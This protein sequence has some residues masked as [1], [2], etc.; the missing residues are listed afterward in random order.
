M[1]CEKK[2]YFAIGAIFKNEAHIMK[3]WLNHYFYHGVDHIYLINDNSNDNFMDILTP[4]LDKKLVTLYD[5]ND[6]TKS[7]PKTSWGE[8]FPE[9][10]AGMQWRKYDFFFEEHFKKYKWFGIFDLDEFLYSPK[11]INTQDILKRLE[12]YKQISI[13]WVHFGSSGFEKQPENVVKNFIK[14]ARYG[15]HHSVKSIIKTDYGNVKEISLRIHMHSIGLSAPMK[16]AF[17]PK[18]NV[19]HCKMGPLLFVNHYRIQSKEF[20]TKIKMTR[21]DADFHF[22]HINMKRD[23]ALFKQYDINDI[24]DTVLKK[25][26]ENIKDIC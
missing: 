4:F 17:P 7:E 1:S 15:A 13:S 25:Q 14:R 22:D 18:F 19:S 21:G 23:L 11:C 10:F 12:N 2:L 8:K 16:A 6:Y 24:E 9:K 20:W 26:N 3:E 5:G